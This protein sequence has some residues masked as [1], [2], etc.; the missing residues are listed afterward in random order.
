[1][2]I[3]IKH[4]VVNQVM[5]PEMSGGCS[6]MQRMQGTYLEQTREMFDT[7]HIG[8]NQLMDDKVRGVQML[9]KKYS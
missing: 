5:L 6:L 2:H 3:N 4:I 8:V 1:M 9:F 7:F